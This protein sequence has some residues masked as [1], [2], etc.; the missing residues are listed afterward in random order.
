MPDSAYSAGANKKR[1][2][3]V[4]FN[5]ARP[6]S[7]RMHAARELVRGGTEC[8]RAAAVISQMEE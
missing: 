5:Q 7:F 2:R 8:L 1:A 3:A 4:D 6:I